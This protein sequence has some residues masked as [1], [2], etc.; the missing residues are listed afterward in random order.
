MPDVEVL[1]ILGLMGGAEDIAVGRI[2][3]FGAHLVGESVGG[4]ERR[5]F[6]AAAQLVD[7]LLVE[8]GLVDPQVRIGQQSVAVEPLD[9][10]AL[11]GGAVAP[12][13][14]AILLHCRYQH[15]A[16]H[17]AAERGGV[18]VRN[19]AGRDVEGA[20]LDGGNAFVDQLRAAIHEAGFLGAEL[21]RFT[22]N[23]VVV[24]LVGLAEVRGIGK[25][26]GAFL[27]HP[28]AAPRWC[29]A[30]PRKRC[31]R[32]RLWAGFSGSYSWKPF[33]ALCRR[34]TRA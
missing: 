31:R 28:Q 13:V 29:R 23:L 20:G 25:D 2:G 3:L 26:A 10:V 14:D 33:E 12:D 7:E 34:H 11:V 32:F 4:H 8:P 27:L 22:R 18:E 16:G 21:E 17:G 24:G 15:R 1:E 9:V 30:R 5:H 6:R 19:A